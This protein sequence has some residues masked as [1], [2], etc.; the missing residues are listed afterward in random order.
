MPKQSIYLTYDKTIDALDYYEKEMNAKITD[1]RFVT[2]EMNEYYKLPEDTLNGSIFFAEFIIEGIAFRCSDK[3]DKNGPINDSFNIM[4]HYELEE[5]EEFIKYC[6]VL[7]KARGEMIYNNIDTD[8]D[9]IMYRFK[10]I[11]NV[12]WSFVLVK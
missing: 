1:K 11:Y 9:M 10:D 2:P 12:I 4:M 3:L 5:K 6:E 7:K 8:E